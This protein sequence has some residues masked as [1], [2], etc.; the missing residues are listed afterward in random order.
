M[1]IPESIYP[2]CGHSQPDYD[3]FGV[4]MCNACKHCVHAA[5]DLIDGLWVC[6]VCVNKSEEVA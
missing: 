1:V 2:K 3:G 5:Q 4:L 6:G